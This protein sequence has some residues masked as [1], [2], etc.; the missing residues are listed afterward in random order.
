MLCRGD[1]LVLHR[2]G[3]TLSNGTL[4]LYGGPTQHRWADG[5]VNE[6]P[7]VGVAVCA[8]GVV[9]RRIKITGTNYW[10]RALRHYDTSDSTRGAAVLVHGGARGVLLE[11]C[12]L[13]NNTHVGI[14]VV[15]P[16]TE[17]HLARW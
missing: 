13:E 11:D 3:V 10:A 9:L 17:V 4:V 2:P 15:G 8:P 12:V 1:K 14:H 5:S 6:V 7:T 16:R